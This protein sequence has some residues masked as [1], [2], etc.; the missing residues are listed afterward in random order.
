MKYIT[1]PYLIRLNRRVP[2]IRCLRHQFVMD[3]CLL[4][5]IVCDWA[6]FP[7]RHAPFQMLLFE[8]LMIIAIFIYF[9]M[10]IIPQKPSITELLFTF[11][12]RYPTK[13][14]SRSQ[15]INVT[16][17]LFEE[18]VPVFM[19]LPFLFSKTITGAVIS[20]TIFSIVVIADIAYHIL[21]LYHCDEYIEEAAKGMGLYVKETNKSMYGRVK[22]KK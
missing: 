12:C 3:L 13:N 15:F 21:I 10:L 17:W 2:L 9:L 8:S 14:P 20:S 19:L 7:A 22:K 16:G 6:R 1:Q 4:I 18:F 5:A 11:N